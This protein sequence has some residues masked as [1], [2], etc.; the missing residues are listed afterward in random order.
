MVNL[1]TIDVNSILNFFLSFHECWSL[2]VKLVIGLAMLYV[3]MRQAILVGFCIAVGLMSVNFVVAKL[4]GRYF[5]RGMAWKD[6]RMLLLREFVQAPK[7]IK[8]LKWERKWHDSVT[9]IRQ[10]EFRLV[11]AT[12]WLDSLCV[13]F[14]AVTNT[15]ISTG[16]LLYFGPDLQQQNVFTII[17]L[18]SL[19]TNPLNSLP[20]TVS[21]M[22]QARHS[23]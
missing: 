15:L 9:H 20:W 13:L 18:F 21:G 2:V 23:F 10:K 6:K 4:I 7:Q 8:Y 16:T 5:A 11:E 3:Q 22:L 1:V 17:Y 14:W 19:L 12:K